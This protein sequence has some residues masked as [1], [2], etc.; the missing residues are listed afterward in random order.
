MRIGV[1]CKP[2][3]EGAAGVQTYL[4]NLLRE[5]AS[6]SELQ[7]VCFYCAG[8]QPPDLPQ[9]VDAG[10]V[11]GPWINNWIW[12]EWQLPRA[13]WRMSR[14]ECRV[15][16]AGLKPGIS[17]Q[18]PATPGLRPG[19]RDVRP[20][21]PDPRS[22][23]PNLQPVTCHLQPSALDLFHFPAYTASSRLPCRK[24]VSVHDVSYA[25]HPEWYPHAAGKA[26][27]RFYRRSAERSDH[28]ITIS[29]F[30]RSEILRVYAVSPE[31][32]TSIP[33]ASGLE[34][35]NGAPGW[36]RRSTRRRYLLHVG[37]LHRRRNLLIAIEAFHM[38]ASEQDLD[39]VF[40]GKDLGA[41]EA[42]RGHAAR[43]G[44]AGRLHFLQDLPLEQ[45]PPWYANAVAL[46][47]PSLYEGFGL[48]LLEAMQ[49]ACPVVASRAASIP[50]VTG[51]AAWLVDPLNAGE[52]AAGI[53]AILRQPETRE[54]L[55]RKGKEQAARFSWKKTAA[56]TTA[57]YRE[58]LMAD[59]P[60][61]A[62]VE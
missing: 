36:D 18:Q 24:V 54:L 33:L 26:R 11:S 57:V 19:A 37:D 8:L 14:G 41:A 40:I 47:Y 61:E 20:A 52:I 3:Q 31:R 22:A 4:R 34:A 10:R 12:M 53:G 6:V 44:C 13:V 39:F 35:I 17:D 50:E 1:D 9:G 42:V 51:D 55:V 48:P 62:P 16:N 7:L 29:H 21:A 5:L 28:I 49:C 30:S 59:K 43:L 46:V 2:L 58:V 27:Q 45:M 32:V 60:N 25:T 56:A 38:V 15:A 23:T